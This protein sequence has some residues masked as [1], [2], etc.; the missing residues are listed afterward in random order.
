MVSKYW[1]VLA[2]FSSSAIG[3]SFG[4]G[5][6]PT[7]VYTSLTGWKQEQIKAGIGSFFMC[8]GII[9]ITAQTLAGLQSTASV[10]LAMVA[11]PSAVSGGWIGIRISRLIGDFS[12]RKILFTLLGT[13]GCMI[14][15]KATMVLL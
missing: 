3:T 9:M 10:T 5:G 7:I 14:L 15:Y 1:G 11:V 2:G 4:M 13:M 6:P 8:A 12:Y